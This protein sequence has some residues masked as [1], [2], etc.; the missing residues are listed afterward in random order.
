MSRKHNQFS[1]KL[2]TLQIIRAIAV[3]SVVYFHIRATPV[4][5]SFGVDI[6]FVLSGFVMALL[7]RN[8]QSPT[9]FAINR[10]T[11]IIPLYWILTT[12]VLVI[13]AFRPDLLDLTTSNISN[14]IK[15]ILFIPHFKNNGNLY[16][17]LSVGWSLNYEMFFYFC[18][19][20]SIIFAKN[21]YI[22]ITSSI[23]LISY[24]IFGNYSENSVLQSFFGNS[25]VFEFLFGIFAFNL[26]KSKLMPKCNALTSIFIAA[27]SF[28]LMA[29]LELANYENL[30]H[31]LKFGL[32][33]I[34]L[35]LALV[36]LEETDFIK[37][38]SL[39]NLISIVGDASFAIYLSH[40]YIISGIRKIGFPKLNI[41][42]PNKQLEVITILFTCTLAGLI[43]YVLVDKPLSKYFKKKLQTK[44][45][46]HKF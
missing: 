24:L 14:Y 40:Y 9:I 30:A 18:I 38:N 33:S 29:Y 31:V 4:F 2:K 23:L 17:M 15:S 20:I 26:Y 39:A 8:G 41:I 7:M 34:I 28:G 27:S 16:P 32:P 37:K 46:S 36:G 19:W 43:L 1:G 11:R 10:V 12:G 35:I 42:N 45:I 13:A 22:S 3:I 6:F 25:R 44:M 21:L 5:G